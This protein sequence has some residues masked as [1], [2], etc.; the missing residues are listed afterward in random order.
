MKPVREHK[1]VHADSERD[2]GAAVAPA[3]QQMSIPPLNQAWNRRIRGALRSF[4][5]G[6]KLEWTDRL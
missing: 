6:W 4:A 2:G 1:N 5:N 3:T